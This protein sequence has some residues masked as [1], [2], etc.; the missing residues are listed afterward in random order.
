MPEQLPEMIEL[1][2]NQE[3]RSLGRGFMTVMDQFVQRIPSI[4]APTNTEFFIGYFLGGIYNF[5]YTQLKAELGVA[6]SFCKYDDNN[7]RLDLVFKINDQ[8][9]NPSHLLLRSIT[10][11]RSKDS[12]SAIKPTDELAY[13]DLVFKDTLFAELAYKNSKHEGGLQFKKIHAQPQSTQQLGGNSIEKAEDKLTSLG[14]K[15]IPNASDIKG[16]DETNI[17]KLSSGEVT[18][19]N[20][21]KAYLTG[22]VNLFTKAKAVFSK[23]I[24]NSIKAEA[25]SH[26]FLYGS[27]SLNFKNR[28]RLDVYVERVAG[29]GYADLTMISRANDRH[30][31]AIPIVI[32]LKAGKATAKQA[33]E[34]I[35]KVGYCQ[36]RLSLR[37]Y[38]QN[39]IIAGVN[40]HSGKFEVDEV[41]I[42]SKGNIIERLLKTCLD[43]KSA[44][45]VKQ[46]EIRENLMSL[47]SSHLG[48]LDFRSLLAQLV[49]HLLSFDALNGLKD[50]SKHVFLPSKANNEIYQQEALLTID[51]KVRDVDKTVIFVLSAERGAKTRSQVTSDS[52]ITPALNFCCTERQKKQSE[53]Q[54]ILIRIDPIKSEL[55]ATDFIAPIALETIDLAVFKEVTT[56]SQLEGEFHKLTT[57]HLRDFFE[58]ESG[59][60]KKNIFSS[61]L[62]R[63]LPAA[64]FPLRRLFQGSV[65]TQQKE[66]SFQAVM[67]GISA[68]FNQ[69]AF[70]VS[71]FTEP[72]HSV[73]G[74]ADLVVTLAKFDAQKNLLSESLF[75]FEFKT[76]TSGHQLLSNAKLARQQ[77]ESYAENAKS[78][79]DAKEAAVMGLVMNSHAKSETDFLVANSATA[80]V[81]HSSA[82]EQMPSPKRP[83]TKRKHT[84]RDNS[85]A[86]KPIKRRCRR[87]VGISCQLDFNGQ[88]SEELLLEL[89][90]VRKQGH[91]ILLAE[92]Y[93]LL[94]SL[95]KVENPVGKIVILQE[96]IEAL[97]RVAAIAA[98]ASQAETLEIWLEAVQRIFPKA[99]NSLAL[100][101]EK[102]ADRID[103]AQFKVMLALRQ[104]YW[105]KMQP[106]SIPPA[107]LDSFRQ[108]LG[109]VDA[110]VARIIQPLAH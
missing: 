23:K 94:L 24:K 73:Q 46:Q 106:F 10:I 44:L 52:F 93:A 40:Y 105:V 68:G 103:F 9:N 30:S 97:N 8:N 75:I 33:I 69:A 101:V 104:L 6:A 47:Y 45:S 66:S 31:D 108:H 48:G 71:S 22:N 84:D 16:I 79:T 78:F 80:I 54:K 41:S 98:L 57:L 85:P 59:N 63:N 38:H 12:A 49:G 109:I 27:L 86:R 29:T 19:K 14:F 56:A 89:A 65:P 28:Y 55:R 83:S 35:K 107:N 102:L 1:L 90:D 58:L 53:V 42:V 64:L 82:D 51:F 67:Q 15:K 87:S 74:R 50:I 60:F 3:K 76:L 72:N 5:Q 92:H 95:F 43:D 2:I 61:G 62:E 4:H 37:T 13:N 11:L 99:A 96:S 110:S 81:D 88:D 18:V 70:Q 26:G 34:Q 32:E 91:V 17:E 7:K 36:H 25:F 100:G 77:A 21:L 39:A 20:A